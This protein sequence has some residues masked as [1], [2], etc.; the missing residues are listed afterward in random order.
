MVDEGLKKGD[1]V[2]WIKDYT[3]FSADDKGNAWPHDPVYEYGLVMEVS[4]TDPNALIVFGFEA[5]HLFIVDL[6]ID[7]VEAISRAPRRLII[8]TAEEIK[9]YE[10]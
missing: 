2:R 8:P 1:L 3:F 10:K 9:K 4:Y 7:E 5:K 6:D